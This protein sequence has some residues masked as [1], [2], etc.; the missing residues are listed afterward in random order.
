MTLETHA[1]AELE[2]I[3]AFDYSKDFYCGMTG[4]AVMELIRLFAKQGH[5]GMSA[6]LV[7]SLFNK[8]ASYEPLSPLTGE[9]SE[10]SECSPGVW[11]NKRCSH[12]FK[13]S[14]DGAY[15]IDGKVFREPSGATYTSRDSRVPVVFPYTPQLEY[16]DV[17]TNQ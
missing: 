1:Q 12:V 2:A 8:L 10:W 3:G 6:G 13:T 11:Q 14:E 5:S 15:D 17:E 9:D 4:D 16:V 7:R